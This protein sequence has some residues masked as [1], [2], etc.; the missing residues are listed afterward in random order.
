MAGTPDPDTIYLNGIDP[1]TG[2][3]AVPP[4]TIA[5]LVQHVAIRPG[6]E[7]IG[8]KHGEAV[9]GFHMPF[10]V[11]LQQLDETGWGIV[12]HEDTPQEVRNAVAPLIEHRRKQAGKR[13][14]ILTYKQGEQV[15]DW[16]ERHDISAGNVDSAIVP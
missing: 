15:R 9:R 4:V 5:S 8:L 13:F 1:E 14:R 16:Y 2:T 7:E 6:G 11:D 10:G 12:F 3:Y